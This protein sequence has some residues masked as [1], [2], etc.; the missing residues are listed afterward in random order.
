MSPE[1]LAVKLEIAEKENRLPKVVVPV[2]LCGQSCDM[3]AIATLGRGVC[4]RGPGVGRL[5]ARSCVQA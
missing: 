4:P 3:E 5:S 2:H 1:A